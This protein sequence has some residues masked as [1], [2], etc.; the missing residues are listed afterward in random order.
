MVGSAKLGFSIAPENSFRDFKIDGETPSDIDIA[1]I[2][3]QLFDYFWRLFRKSYSVTNKHFYG[4]ITRGIYR[5]YIS[6]IDLKRI[7]ECREAWIKSSRMCT[8]S[9]QQNMYFQHEIHY[10]IYR[11][12]KD[13]EEYHIQSLEQ[14]REEIKNNA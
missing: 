5:G 10:R 8:K 9:L 4:Y 6:D 1:I 3:P 14:L 2:S 7:E 11:D 13:L 12:W